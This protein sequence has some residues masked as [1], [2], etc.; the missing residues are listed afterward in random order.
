MIRYRILPEH[1]LMVMCFEGTSTAGEILALSERLRSDPMFSADYD[2]LADN[3][4]VEHPP[5]GA[6]LRALAE[7]RMFMMRDD[8]KLAVVA[9]ADATY[10][11]SRMHQL[12]AESRS[13][14]RIEVFRDRLSALEW[15]GREGVDI[16]RI[17]EEILRES[18]EPPALGGA[19]DPN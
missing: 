14:L 11:T 1:K 4:N 17:C 9:P 5:T 16:E 13:P 18:A 2:A 15:L 19:D 12:L 3:T 7:P 8:A 6:E 10:G